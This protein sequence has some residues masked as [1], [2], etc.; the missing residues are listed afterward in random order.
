VIITQE[1]KQDENI[2]LQQLQMKTPS[3]RGCGHF[4]LLTIVAM[5]F[6]V[7]IW[8]LS[9]MLSGVVTRLSSRVVVS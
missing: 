4:V 1:D 2:K 9:L 7:V 5:S 3:E 8:V 6:G